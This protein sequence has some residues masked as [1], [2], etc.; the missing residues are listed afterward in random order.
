MNPNLAPT[1]EPRQCQVCHTRAGLKRCKW[2]KLVFYCGREHQISHRASHKRR[3]KAV[4]KAVKVLGYEEHKL[5][6]GQHSG[7][8]A[9]RNVF[10]HCP[11][12]RFWDIVDTTLDYMR[13]LYDAAD[14]MVMQF[15]NI[16]AVETA[17]GHL[18]N[19]LRLGRI[20]PSRLRQRI[21]SLYLRLGRDQECYNFFK[22][23]ATSD[24]S[25]D[26]DWYLRDADALEAPEALWG[27]GFVNNIGD[28]MYV[29][30][31][32]VRILFDL[33][34]MQNATRAFQGFILPELIDEIRVH[35]LV[36][37]VVTAR[38]DIVLA[39]V[40]RMGDLIQ[41]IRGQ[42]KLLFNIIASYSPGFWPI[43]VGPRSLHREFWILGDPSFKF[44]YH[45]EAWNETPGAI[46]L[47]ESLMRAGARSLE[48]SEE[49]SEQ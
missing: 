16:D 42:I 22:W 49:P 19:L 45:Y 36:S 48:S 28:S 9:G 38:N 29:L 44:E 32:K 5:R 13:A 12:G 34:H 21:A 27:G 24:K 14:V 26:Y 31:I 6:T 1:L 25:N 41:Q 46:E 43:F 11:V 40:E 3:C 18:T 10:E 7:A 47:I 33:Q 17:L 35:A 23:Y 37:G 20:A 2:C 30:L 39:S 8:F 15:N 4:K